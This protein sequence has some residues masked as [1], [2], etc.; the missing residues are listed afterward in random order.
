MVAGLRRTPSV[1]DDMDLPES[2]PELAGRPTCAETFRMIE[3]LEMVLA[4]SMR[5]SMQVTNYGS[6][7]TFTE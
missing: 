1:P 4:Y 3:T 7:R 2:D 6:S 5:A